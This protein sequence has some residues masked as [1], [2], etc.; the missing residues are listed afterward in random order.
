MSRLSLESNFANSPDQSQMQPLRPSPTKPVGDHLSEASDWDVDEGEDEGDANVVSSPAGFKYNISRLSPRT[1]QIAKSLF[2]QGFSNEPPQISLDFCGLR[3]EDPEGNGYFYAFQMHEVV[4]CSVRIGSKDSGRLSIPRCEC[5]DA[6]YRHVMPCK[7]LIWLFDKISKQAL[8]DHD[9]ESELTLTEQGYPEELE[10]AFDQISQIRLDV[11]ADD[12]RCDIS[13][14]DSDV[15]PASSARVREAREMVAAV[16]GIYPS[17][18]DD[19][20]HSFVDSYDRDTLIRRGDLE[21][22]LF[23]LLLSS[24]S[25]AQ[26]IRSQL[27][28]SDPAV[29]PS[30]VAQQR[31][32]RVIQELKL[33][34]E[35]ERDPKKA[36]EYLRRGKRAEGPRDLTWAATQIQRCVRKI[37]KL[38]SRGLTPLS[39]SE[40]WSAAKSLV[41]ILKAVVIHPGLYG[42]LIG[43]RDTGFVFSTLDMLVDQSDFIDELEDIM[44]T[45]GFLG[46]PPSYVTNMRRLIERMRSHKPENIGTTVGSGVPR[47]ETP[48]LSESPAPAVQSF[49]PS[50]SNSGQCPSERRETRRTR[51]RRTGQG[52]WTG[53]EAFHL[54]K[55]P[56]RQLQG[57]VEE[58]A[59]GLISN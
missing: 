32:Y 35:A 46:A 59:R 49:R 6:R 11:L 14:P 16:A 52:Q 39:E 34:S 27:R 33:Y 25:L 17:D 3:E 40:R 48:P 28:P 36:E 53:L 22:T 38:V 44:E 56:R 50:S 55:Q 4:P 20:G 51:A 7:H 41:S 47:S 2:A 57:F 12:L 43:D 26:W 5:P 19:Y 58:S 10:D 13:E 37:E 23:S 21:A 30:R 18:L 29:D 31:V 54:S 1:R 24:H 8:F 15:F 42:Q 45:I 9:P